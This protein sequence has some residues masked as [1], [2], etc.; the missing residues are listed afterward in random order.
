[1]GNFREKYREKEIFFYWRF[2]KRCEISLRIKKPTYKIKSVQ[3]WLYCQKNNISVPRDVE[4]EFK[5]WLQNKFENYFENHSP[6]KSTRMWAIKKLIEG[7]HDQEVI[8]LVIS[9]ANKFTG[10]MPEEDSSRLK[11]MFRIYDYINSARSRNITKTKAFDK[12]SKKMGIKEDSLRREFFAF[13][14]QMKKHGNFRKIL[15]NWSKLLRK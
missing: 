10:D 4:Y 8:K 1:M 3:L 11:K 7:D 5:D 2:V 14:K 6:K 9:W 13:Q 15:D 12:C